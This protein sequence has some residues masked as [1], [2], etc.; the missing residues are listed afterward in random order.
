MADLPLAGNGR[1]GLELAR[2]IRPGPTR[3]A[4][5]CRIL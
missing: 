5:L 1:D 4:A 2:K 3:G